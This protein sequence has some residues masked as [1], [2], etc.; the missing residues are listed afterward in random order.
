[1]ETL[2]VVAQH[3]V[4]SPLSVDRAALFPRV[5]SSDGRWPIWARMAFLLGAS[6]ALWAMIGWTALRIFQ[7]G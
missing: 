2:A 7:L 1:M 4:A 6:L 5:E 3:R